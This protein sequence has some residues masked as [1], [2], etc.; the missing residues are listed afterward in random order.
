MINYL[1]AA[2]GA[3]FQKPSFEEAKASSHLC[4][5]FALALGCAL[6]GS[7]HPREQVDFRTGRFASQRLRLRGMAQEGF[8]ALHVAT[9]IASAFFLGQAYLSK[10]PTFDEAALKQEVEVLEKKRNHP[11]ACAAV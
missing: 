6:E 11:T 7:K 5:T 4:H 2:L 1:Q 10:D 9:L 8:V 3:L